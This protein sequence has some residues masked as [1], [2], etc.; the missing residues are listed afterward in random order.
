MSIIDIY[1][2]F[3]EGILRDKLAWLVFVM[4][5]SK[6]DLKKLQLWQRE[7]ILGHDLKKHIKIRSLDK[8]LKKSK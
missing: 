1:L 7:E 5:T 6:R 8:F 2:T 4:P 3:T